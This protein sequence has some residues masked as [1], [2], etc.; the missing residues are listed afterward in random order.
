[1]KLWN[2]N[3]PY[4]DENIEFKPF[5][6]PYI[7]ENSR[8]GIVICAGGAYGK[9]SDHEGRGY[10]EWLNSIGISAIVLDYRVAPYMAP[11]ECADVQRAMRVAKYEFGKY[12]IDKVGIMGSSAG[13]HLAA[14]ASIHYSEIF[15]E[16]QDEIDSI[17][18][19]PDFTILCYPVVDF[20]DFRHDVTKSNLIGRRPKKSQKEFYSMQLQ[21][22][23][24]TPKTFIWHTANDLSVPAE[25][26]IMY[27]AALSAHKI[28]Y[29]LHIYPDG[30]HGLGLAEEENPYVAQWTDALKRWLETYV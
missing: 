27:A 28:P 16:P 8:L 30:R 23:D 13:G 18:A 20:G 29:E 24:D 10:A 15:Y 2:K 22:R 1:M 26:S 5:I 6:T 11:A 9:R 14:V 19:R 25:N 3:I 12:G 7:V 17:S 4:Y 21:V